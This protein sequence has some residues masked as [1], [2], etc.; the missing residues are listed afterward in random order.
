MDQSRQ[1]QPTRISRCLITGTTLAF[2]ATLIM[3]AFTWPAVYAQPRGVPVGLVGPESAAA[4]MTTALESARPHEFT[5]IRY[6]T[7]EAAVAAIRH[8]E[9]YGA[10]VVAE[11]PELLAA[12]GASTVAAQLL[13]GLAPMLAGGESATSER[14]TVT[15]VVPL[16]KHDDQ[17]AGL[18]ASFFPLLLG[19]LKGGI[20][21]ALGVQGTTR[22]LLTLAVLAGVAGVAVAVVGQLAFRILSGALV[23]NIAASGLTI[24]AIAATVIGLRNLIGLH[25][26]GV[27]TVLIMLVGSPIS[28]AMLPVEFLPG[29]WGT[30]GQYFPPGASVSLIRTIS[31]FPDASMLSQWS[32]LGL[33]TVGGVSLA[34]ATSRRPQA[35]ARS[36]TP[37]SAKAA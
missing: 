6:P 7:R 8:R 30:V 32:V 13:T 18:S 34:I 9:V 2:V 16:S 10:V 31:Y 33:W 15:D 23:L 37:P 21:I 28:A 19:G 25:G 36:T 14:I 11:P 29:P 17:G 1:D 27:G 3:A 5:V 35:W 24:A 4:E 12:S 20:F 22:R 26:V